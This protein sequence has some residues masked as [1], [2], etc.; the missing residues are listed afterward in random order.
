MPRLAAII[1]AAG[2]LSGAPVAAQ[3][4]PPGPWIIDLRGAT[5]SLPTAASFFPGLPADTLVP[6]RGFGFDVGAHVYLLTLGPSRVGV[7]A[8]YVR[9]RGT[10]QGVASTLQTLAPQV[11]FNFG[12]NRGWSYLGAGIGRASLRMT[13]NRGSG[14][15]TSESGGTSAINV[16]GGARWFLA[17]HLA[18]GF[19]VRFHRLAR[20]QKTTLAGFSVGLSVR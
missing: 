4:A 8:N 19:D 3:T 17:R 7:G 18:V 20:P 12:T 13:V 2:V 5:T 15:L 10:A 1:V 11:S 16:G 14:D 9:T 6:A